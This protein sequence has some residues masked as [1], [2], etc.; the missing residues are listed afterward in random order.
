MFIHPRQPMAFFNGSDERMLAN[1]YIERAYGV[2][3]DFDGS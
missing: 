3:R 1:D 2:R